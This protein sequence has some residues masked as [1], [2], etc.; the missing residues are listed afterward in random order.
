MYKKYVGTIVLN[1]YHILML[2]YNP[3]TKQYYYQSNILQ[4]DH[5]Q[6]IGKLTRTTREYI[7]T[8]FV[9]GALKVL[10]FLD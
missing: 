5:L 2:F 1:P 10:L 9:K 6:P 3:M 7:E 4:E 8:E